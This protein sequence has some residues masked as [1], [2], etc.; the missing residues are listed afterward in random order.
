M[1]RLISRFIR[2]ETG[3]DM[4]EYTLLVA[5]VT[6]CS[7]ALF[8]HNSASIRTIWQVSNNSLSAAS[9]AAKSGRPV[10]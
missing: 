5:F 9:D 7:A 10:F 1:R 2:E 8:L 4:V 6:V 3:Q